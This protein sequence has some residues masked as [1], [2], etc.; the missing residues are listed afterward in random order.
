[1]C[2]H[3]NGCGSP[4]VLGLQV[5]DDRLRHAHLLKLQHRRRQ[6]VALTDD[7]EFVPHLQA[8]D[9][10]ASSTL[11]AARQDGTTIENQAED[12]AA[13]NSSTHILVLLESHTP[14][15]QLGLPAGVQ[16]LRVHHALPKG[17]CTAQCSSRCPCTAAVLGMPTPCGL[18]V[19]SRG[20]GRCIAQCQKHEPQ[21][22]HV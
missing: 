16:R 1:M 15:L 14:M 11:Q 8:C 17:S 12:G 18:Q 4:N 13:C 22:I 19:S 3:L 10:V 9:T 2:L 5:A 7:V 6:V 21:R 20:N